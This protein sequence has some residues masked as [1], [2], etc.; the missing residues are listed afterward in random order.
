MNSSVLDLF[1]D[2]LGHDSPVLSPRRMKSTR[3]FYTFPHARK[4]TK[5]GKV[6]EGESQIDL[7]GMDN[8]ERVM[9]TQYDF[10]FFFEATEGSLRAWDLL[11]SRMR[12]GTIPWNFMVADCNPAHAAHWLNIRADERRKVSAELA[13]ELGDR[14]DPNAPK[15]Y[16]V[17]T[18]LKDNPK[19]W[20][21]ANDCWTP[22]GA[23]YNII[24]SGMS[25]TEQKRLMDG[26]W[27]SQHGQVYG[28]F[29]H[30]KHV[31]QGRLKQKTADNSWWLYPVQIL[32][33][34]QK[35]VLE[36]DF[37]KRRIKWFGIGVDWGYLPDPGTAGLYAVDYEDRV[38]L[39]KEAYVTQKGMDWWADL[40][41]GWQKEFDV[42]AI[43]CDVSPER[44]AKLNDMLGGKLN[45]K[46]EPIAQA[47]KKGP[48]SILAGIEVMRFGLKDD[49]TGEPRFRYLA[50]APQI[51]D[52]LL[53]DRRIPTGGVLE[54]SSYLY[55][56]HQD[57]K[58]NKQLPLDMH[59]HA[60]DRDRYFLTYAW[61]NTH[62]GPRAPRNPEL[63]HPLY[64]SADIETPA[65]SRAALI[66][67]ARANRY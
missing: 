56:P 35:P 44:C 21:Y 65:Q 23:A 63:D 60:M 61:G 49:E 39:V 27:V 37:A 47:A 20:D 16:R 11:S 15:M 31:I 57:D 29:H 34:K 12:R 64:I 6:Y 55:P 7:L 53:I 13:A 59:N 46:G 19:Y 32:D 51:E 48:G 8:P 50:T 62:N 41:I 30:D 33:W 17:C 67:E 28:D 18:K 22:E 5:S 4:V 54:F 36:G 3:D 45:D 42:R 10:M 2:I 26:L 58:T 1:E 25:P 38:F 14:F 24:L 43:I 9:S 66:R 52:Q 40:I